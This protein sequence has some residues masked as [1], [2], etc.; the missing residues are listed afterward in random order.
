MKGMQA[1]DVCA[2]RACFGDYLIGPF[3]RS[4]SIGLQYHSTLPYSKG[5]ILLVYFSAKE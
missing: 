5:K 4:F 2:L 1:A 3:I